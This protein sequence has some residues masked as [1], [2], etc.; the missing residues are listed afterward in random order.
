MK[1]KLIEDLKRHEGVR[2]KVYKC[3]EGFETIGVG[4][5]ISSSGIGL[6]D[7]EIDFLLLN[8]IERCEKE[9][10]ANFQWFLELDAVRREAIINMCFNLGIS[11]LKGF[12]NA[13]AAMESQDYTTAADEFLD[14]R[15]AKQVGHRAIEV[16]HMIETGEYYAN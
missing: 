3:T 14:S 7:T 9:L 8:D 5:N 13:I 16:T 2:S 10:A 4:R 12:K 11:R 15:W 6:S 1:A